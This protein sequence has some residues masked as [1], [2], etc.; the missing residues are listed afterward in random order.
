MKTTGF[1]EGDRR[2]MNDLRKEVGMQCCLR[3]RLVR[4]RM[5]CIKDVGKGKATV[6][7]GGLCEEEYEKIGRERK[8][9]A[10]RKLW[11]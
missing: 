6:E 8:G 3:G 5:R 2:R 9:D 1:D 7:M 4:S 10:D 11:K